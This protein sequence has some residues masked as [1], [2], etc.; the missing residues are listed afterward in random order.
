MNDRIN[1][2]AAAAAGSDFESLSGDGLGSVNELWALCILDLLTAHGIKRAVLAPGARSS[3]M[4]L[5]ARRHP[6]MI[7]T[8]VVNDERSGAYLALG[9]AKATGEPVLVIT[10]SG[11]AVANL[12][13]AL[14]E[15]DLCGTQLI[16]VSCDRPRDMRNTG[17]GQMTDHVGACAAFVRASVDLEDPQDSPDAVRAMHG[18]ITSALA[19][20]RGPKPGPVHLNVPL[21]G[22]FYALELSDKPSAETLAV[23]DELRERTRDALTATAAASP[24][25]APSR[26][27]ALAGVLPLRRGLR[28]LIVAGP[29]CEV[30]PVALDAFCAATGYP[31]LADASSG[32]RGQGR[33]DVLSGFDALV[34]RWAL[35]ETPPDLIIRLGHA[36][37]MPCVQDYLLA[38]QVPTLKISP[39]P[40]E[41]DYLHSKFAAL[42]APTA[43]ELEELA[44][45]LGPGDSDWREAWRL[46]ATGVRSV[47][48]VVLENQLWGELTAVR[49]AL[50][51]RGF[52]LLC[53]GNSMSI[54]HADMLDD[55]RVRRSHVLSNRGVCGIDGT[56]STFLGAAQ[57]TECEAGMLVIG[58]LGMLHDLPA[59]TTANRHTG[60]AC[61]V[62][63]HN[64][65]GA[66]FDFLSLSTHAD[67]S[68]TIRNSHDVDFCAV[69]AGFGLSHSRVSDMASLNAAL[70]AARQHQGVSLVEIRVDAESARFQSEGVQSLL[71]LLDMDPIPKAPR[72]AG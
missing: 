26:I 30:D 39:M 29:E 33:P 32:L 31:V 17:F 38:N 2:A 62:V 63:V 34:A 20:G 68:T 66:I 43:A 57:A 3:A 61:I 47:R 22:R 9:M 58:D 67:Y 52:D 69:A 15:A 44:A 65:G 27:A 64:G 12:V 72:R 41:A 1:M 8:Q 25:L 45:R 5:A 13:P 16:I 7:H 11:S 40:A 49:A 46:Q 42:V 35:C 21:S 70:D 14:T 59:L 6:G 50:S 51:H 53:I 56:V 37:V 54:R 48:N 71:E 28:G 24:A 36:P 4:V 18:A 10:T 60:C 55:G 23:V 19:L